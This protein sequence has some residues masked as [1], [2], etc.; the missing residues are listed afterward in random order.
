MRTQ[1]FCRAQGEAAAGCDALI[2]R[3]V[4]DVI[5]TQVYIHGATRPSLNSLDYTTYIKRTVEKL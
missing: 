4:R 5:S 3:E 2:G 1:D